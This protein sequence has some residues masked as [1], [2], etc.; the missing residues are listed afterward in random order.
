MLI[1]GVTTRALAVSAARG[2][3]RVTAVDAFGDVDLRAVADVIALTRAAGGFTAPAA[4]RAARAVAADAVVYTSNLE[5]HPSA[6]EQ[7]ARGR[8]LL[9]NPASVIRRVR[10]PVELMRLLARHGI[11][12]PQTRA[13]PPTTPLRRSTRWLLKRRRSGGGRGIV[14]WRGGPVGRGGY[15]QERIAGVP[16]S[17]IFAADGRRAVPLGLTRQLVGDPELGGSGFVY[18]G[19]LLGPGLFPREAELAERAS[20]LAGVVTAEYGLVGLN[21]IDFIARDGVPYPIEVNPR[22]CASMELVERLGGPTLF[23]LHERACR[24]VLPARLPVPRRVA[25][26]A[27]VFARRTVTVGGLGQGH[28]LADIPHAGERI[29]R[30]HPICTVFA[31]GRDGPECLRALV[32]RARAIYAAVEPRARGAA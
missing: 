18:C 9:G 15:L 20:A 10:R 7:L 3:H 22:P 4:A 19:S 28:D 1:A 12:V 13:S 11:P 24:G 26:K 25:G 2:G 6:V 16:G 32:V 17:V 5:N 27:I 23:E 29:G 30:G 31:D 14:G 8:T 21:G